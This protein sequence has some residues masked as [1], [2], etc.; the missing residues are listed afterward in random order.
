M[1]YFGRHTLYIAGLVTV[2]LILLVVGFI[3][4]LASSSV[5]SWATGLCSLSI[6]LSVI[7]PSALY[8]SPYSRK[9][10]TC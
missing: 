9:V 4:I 3:S 10:P 6:H 7:P 5:L 1:T 2:L 8:A